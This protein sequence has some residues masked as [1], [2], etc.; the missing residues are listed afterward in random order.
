MN[1]GAT[2]ITS[3]IRDFKGAQKSLGLEVMTP[4][5]LIAALLSKGEKR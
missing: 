5:Q 3:N 4:E 1:A 2:V